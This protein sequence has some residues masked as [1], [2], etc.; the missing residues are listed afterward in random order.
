MHQSLEEDPVLSTA[1]NNP[2]FSEQKKKNN[3]II[4]LVFEGRYFL[5]SKFILI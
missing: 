5:M 4:K 1:N 2:P 3:E